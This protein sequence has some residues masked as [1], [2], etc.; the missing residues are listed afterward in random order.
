MSHGARRARGPSAAARAVTAV[1]AVALIG[2]AWWQLAV[3]A[4]P[5][6]ERV[7]AQDDL[8]VVL[9][10]PDGATAAPGVVVTHGFAG[11]GALMRTWAIALARAGFVVALPDLAGHGTS[12]V[13]LASDDPEQLAGGVLGA[14]QA[15]REQP[16][17]DA[18]RLGLLGHS[19]GSGA[20]MRAALSDPDGVRGVVAVSPTDADVTPVAPPNLLL[21]AGEREPR[22]V[23]N[24]EDLLE[25]AGGA[26]GGSEDGSA[27]D[28][29]IVRGV[30]HVSIL[31]SPT[32]HAASIEWLGAALGHEV[33]RADPVAPILWWALHLVGVVLLWHVVAPV[34]V[35]APSALD[36]RRDRPVVGAIGGAIAATL[37]LAVVGAFVPIDQVAGML[38]APVLAAWFALAGV[39]W[40][41]LGVRPGMVAGRDLGWAV[42]A[43]LVLVAAFG[44]VGALVWLPWWP[45]ARRLLYL[46]A[47]TLLLLPWTLALA[48]SLQGQRRLRAVGWWLAVS[49]VL[50]VTLGA[51]ATVVPGLGFLL[52]LLPLL[53]AVLALTVVVCSPLQRPWAAGLATAVFLG[54]TMA[55]LFPLA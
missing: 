29:R 8:P 41:L 53:P 38:V 47:F 26:G 1:V 49:V 19:M 35:P 17:V 18:E 39:V 32:A 43:L 42:V 37:G 5:Y 44:V 48:S 45:G 31:F 20:V 6:E 50:L 12:T 54:W 16:E 3:I 21:L 27:R 28:L 13:T 40:L 52:L 25:R 11:S 10:L 9:L 15:L 55:I 34:V 30:E 2:A 24:A 51:A 46:P 4:E 22:F 36:T 14:L 33:V 7:T 23:A